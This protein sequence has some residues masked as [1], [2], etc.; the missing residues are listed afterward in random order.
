M[1][2]KDRGKENV[3]GGFV[4]I[5]DTSLFRLKGCGLNLLQATLS[6]GPRI[7]DGRSKVS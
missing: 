7:I 1:A 2:I 6:I 3:G 4:H 5:K